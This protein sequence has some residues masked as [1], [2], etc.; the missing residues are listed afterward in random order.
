MSLA[1]LWCMLKPSGHCSHRIERIDSID[2]RHTTLKMLCCKCNYV[3][4]YRFAN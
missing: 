1:Q 3:F 2:G 4:K